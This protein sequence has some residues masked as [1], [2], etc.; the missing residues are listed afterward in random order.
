VGATGASGPAGADGVI[1]GDGA[2]GATGP[3]G[4][5]GAGATGATGTGG[6]GSTGATGPTGAT[7]SGATGATG[8]N[9]TNGATGATGTGGQPGATGAVTIVGNTYTVQ[10]LY[11]STLTINNLG[12]AATIESG[13][14]LNLKAAGQI[15]VNKPFVLTTATTS[16]LASLGATTQ[17]GA[18]VYVI[19][20]SG[21]A[22]PCFYDGTNWR[23]VTDRTSIA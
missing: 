14:D 6:V 23:Q 17:R 19:D 18:M 10:T 22:Q 1:G 15:T 21:G 2:T 7:G 11:A 8:T 3:E 20:A 12:S 4:P 9:G 5:A 16:Q 13:N